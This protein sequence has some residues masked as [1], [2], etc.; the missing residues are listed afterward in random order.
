M[1]YVYICIYCVYIVSG[2]WFQPTPL[3][4]MTS[5]VGMMNMSQYVEKTI[6][7]CSKPPTKYNLYMYIIHY[8]S[9][10]AYPFGR[11]LTWDPQATHGWYLHLRK[12][13][14]IKG[15]QLLNIHGTVHSN[16]CWYPFISMF[17]S[18]RVIFH[19]YLEVELLEV[20]MSLCFWTRQDAVGRDQRQ[21]TSR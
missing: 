13:C 2:W 6:R 8:L 19:V 3:K 1:I 9:S 17:I 10:T 11:F 21:R 14:W 5:S 15:P 20:F 4:N 18:I 16:V 12:P 7:S